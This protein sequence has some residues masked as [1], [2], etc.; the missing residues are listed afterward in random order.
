ME[1]ALGLEDQEQEEVGV[2]FC[3]LAIQNFSLRDSGDF[4]LPVAG[5]LDVNPRPLE[6]KDDDERGREEKKNRIA[7][8]HSRI[9]SR[10]RRRK[11]A[12]EKKSKGPKEKQKKE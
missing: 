3:Q 6:G 9:T 5:A 12:T 8:Y 4:G 7:N 1:P 10:R 2:H 11:S